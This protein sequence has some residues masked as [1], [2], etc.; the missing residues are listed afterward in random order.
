MFNRITKQC[1]FVGVLLATLVASVAFSEFL[2]KLRPFSVISSPGGTYTVILRGR[3]E[4][5]MLPRMNEVR[6]DILK[7]EASFVPDQ[8]F[9]SGDHFDT[10]FEDGYPNHQWLGENGVHFYD[11][12]SLKEIKP[13]DTLIVFNKTNKVIKYLRLDCSDRDKIFLFD[14]QPESEVS[15][16]ISPPGGDSK[17]ISVESEPYEEQSFKGSGDILL[18][19]GGSMTSTYYLN[20]TD[21]YILFGNFQSGKSTKLTQQN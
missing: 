16:L 10:S 6:F 13:A 8:Y 14:V 21:T 5:P 1:L 19:K 9:L 2:L 4:R 17:S 15:I 11:E 20:I 3:K 12:Y 18:P 7:N